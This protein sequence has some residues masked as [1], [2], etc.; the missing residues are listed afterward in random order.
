MSTNQN[1]S[2]S[3]LLVPSKVVTVDLTGHV[4][5]KI[6]VAYLSREE[7]LKIRK[8]ATTKKFNN[9]TRTMEENMD[10]DTFL[11]L[12]SDATI[13]GWSGMTL[14]VLEKLTLVDV[15]GMDK[16]TELP[17]TPDNA[18]DLMKNSAEF[19]M[20]IS[21]TMSSLESFQTTSSKK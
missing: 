18:L 9:R 14:A 16:T 13:K 12:Y 15:S 20:F 3:S 4:G 7:L 21:D 1:L 6:Q 10:E 5:T 8:K 19:D 11:R 17:Y 2:L